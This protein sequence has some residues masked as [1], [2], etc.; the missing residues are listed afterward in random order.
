L[1]PDICWALVRPVGTAACL[2]RSPRARRGVLL[3]LLALIPLIACAGSPGPSRSDANDEAGRLFGRAY[4]QVMEYYLEPL[5]ARE[6]AL[7]A[8]KKL[9]TLDAEVT[10]SDASGAI[11]LRDAGRLVERVK[12]SPDRDWRDWGT[13]TSSLLHDA[14]L[15]SAKLAALSDDEIEQTMFAGLT[16][17]LDRFSR[18]ASPETAREQRASREGFEGL[19]ITLEYAAGEVRVTAIIPGSPAEREG[20]MVD[21]RLVAIEGVSTAGMSRNEVMQRLRGTAGS[22]IAI[23]LAR[24]GQTAPI[25]KTVARAYVS[26]PT[27]SAHREDGVGIIRISSFN[28]HTTESL[29]SEFAKLRAETPGALR[30]VILDMRGNPGGLLDQS[31]AVADSFMNNGRIVATRGRNPSSFQEFDATTGDIT[32]GLPVVV[33]MNGG[34]ASAA[35]IV[36]AALQDSGRA[37]VVGS[38]SFGKGTVQTVLRLP[39][40]GELTLTWARLI[41]PGGYI[42][43]EHGVVPNVCTSGTPD[44]EPAV[45]A[46]IRKTVAS[47]AAPPLARISLDEQ[48]WSRLRGTCPTRTGDHLADLETAKRLLGDP[49][50]YAHIIHAEPTSVATAVLQPRPAEL[51]AQSSRPATP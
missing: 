6:A 28:Q 39:N 30:G 36:A 45:A 51:S 25:K 3:S 41:T 33:L 4:S 8:L 9:T 21:D 2:G 29:R 17:S 44:D 47:D 42:L 19:G 24:P 22:R 50:L 10:V 48:G 32:G 40:D 15:Q 34:S 5:T 23:A 43:H 31:V 49:S 18:Y 35:E 13:L 1:S 27:V 38:S 37:I 7:A 14:K 16:G 20:I 11:E 26:V 46:A 12:S